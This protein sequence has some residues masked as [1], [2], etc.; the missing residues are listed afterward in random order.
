[1]KNTYGIIDIAY[2]LPED[3]QKLS[4]I[5]EKLDI[6]DAEKK[7][8]YDFYLRSGV[9]KVFCWNKMDI[10]KKLSTL[11]SDLLEKNHR[12]PADI[13]TIYFCN[14]E[15]S[16]L[17]NC[18]NI[19]FCIK[20]MN[21]LKNASVCFVDQICASTIYSFIMAFQKHR[22]DKSQVSLIISLNAMSDLE[23]I[24]NFTVAGDG[25]AVGLIGNS[26]VKY[27]I[28][29]VKVDTYGMYS[30]LKYLSG[31]KNITNLQI[32]KVATDHI[33]KHLIDCN[34]NI[35]DIDSIIAQ[36]TNYMQLNIFAKLLKTDIR[37]IFTCN[38]ALGGHIGD[39][40]T[41]R[42]IKDYYELNPV[43]EQCLLYASGLFPS[44]DIVFVSNIIRKVG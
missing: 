34:L 4:S 9:E 6:T 33:K 15:K 8:K 1:M 21:G 30:Y 24:R 39:V 19:P 14:Y 44:G 43:S 25:C 41:M 10:V 32:A 42:N 35:S 13:E 11:I 29:S 27:E 36:N 12:N 40:D 17:N 22:T 26:C 5:I 38:I 3:T 28:T 16:Y 2:F 23:R 7:S 37:K 18:V 20:E 31:T